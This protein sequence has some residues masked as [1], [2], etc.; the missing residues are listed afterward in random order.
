[1]ALHISWTLTRGAIDHSH[2]FSQKPDFD[3]YVS[4]LQSSTSLA[5]HQKEA[6]CTDVGLTQP[7]SGLQPLICWIISEAAFEHLELVKEEESVLGA[8][9]T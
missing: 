5:S 2:H 4:P 6:G 9:K 3:G 7:Q 1:V 8:V